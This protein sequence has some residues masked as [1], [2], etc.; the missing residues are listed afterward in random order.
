MGAVQPGILHAGVCVCLVSLAG[1]G[2][3]VPSITEFWGDRDSSVLAVNAVANQLQCELKRSVQDLMNDRVAGPQVTQLIS[4]WIVQVNLNLTIEE[5]GQFNPGVS[6]KTSFAPVKTTFSSGTITTNPTFALGIGVNALA[7]TVRV[8]KLTFIYKVSD[9]AQLPVG[10]NPSI[11]VCVQEIPRG[12]LMTQSDLKIGDA[13]RAGILPYTI[14]SASIPPS[15]IVHQVT[16]KINTSGGITPQWTLVRVT[17]STTNPLLGAT[18]NRTQDVIFTFGPS[19]QQE[20]QQPVLAQPAQN[21]AFAAEI[22]SAI[23]TSLQQFTPIP[24]QFT[25]NLQQITP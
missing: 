11:T 10:T 20:G 17:A 2:T 15:A 6:L 7:D 9:L 18:R 23:A 1:C 16:F 3:S 24:Q 8:Q 12:Y 13:L 21:A 19:S 25:P 4:K 22:G 14:Q 5:Q